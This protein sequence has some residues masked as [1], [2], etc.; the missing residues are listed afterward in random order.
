MSYFPAFRA[1]LDAWPSADRVG[2]ARVYG[3]ERSAT[4]FA[5][6]LFGQFVPE[7]SY[8]SLSEI[9]KRLG[10]QIFTAFHKAS[11][12]ETRSITQAAITVYKG[13][14]NQLP[15]ETRTEAEL[16][17]G[18]KRLCERI[19]AVSEL[20]D[21]RTETDLSALKEVAAARNTTAPL[22]RDALAVLGVYHDA[23][24]EVAGQ[25]ELAVA[26]LRTYLDAVNRFLA[27]GRARLAVAG[28][29]VPRLVVRHAGGKEVQ[30][31]TLSSGGRQIVAMMY[32]ATRLSD[33]PVVLIDE[34][35]L[36]LHVDWQRPLLKEIAGL[37]GGKQVIVTT[38]S[39]EVSAEFDL[40]SRQVQKFSPRGSRQP[41]GPDPLLATGDEVTLTRM[42]DD[43]A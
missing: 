24:E 21:R 2:T 33:T 7:V 31:N 32:A 23:L 6:K 28:Q 8:P 25:Q 14:L 1:M 9:D 22:E 36:L 13:T 40:D 38:H 20:L 41:L 11:V 18:I 39:P 17:A 27:D 12:A 30:L 4:S 3:G 26:P 29:G 5:R 42:G 35:E 43:T 19:G 34:P 16:T 37:T 10:N 15:T